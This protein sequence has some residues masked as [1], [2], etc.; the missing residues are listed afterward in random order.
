[1]V[2]AAA[3]LRGLRPALLAA[4][5]SASAYNF[6]FTA[7]YHTLLIDSPADVVTVVVL[8]LV[9]LVTSHLAASMRQQERLAKTHAARNATIAGFAR[10]L[11]SCGSEKDIAEVSTEELSRLF[12]CNAVLVVGRDD[13][14]LV[15]SVP[16]DMRLN[17]G[18]RAAMLLTFG[19]GAAAGRGIG[20]ANLADWQFHPVVSD[21]GVIA[22]LGL[23]RDDGVPPHLDLQ[24]P[25]LGSLLDQ[26]ALA[27]ERA[28]LERQAR[29]FATLRERDRIRLALLASIGQDVKPRLA[30]IMAAARALRRGGSSDKALVSSVAGEAAKL[31]LY[32][33]NLLTLS[34]AS[35]QKPVMAGAVTIDLFRRLVLKDGAE[36]HLTPKEYVV[37]A[38]LAKH[39]D[40]VLSHAYLLRTAWGPAHEA[41]ID[42]LRVA[43][44]ALRQKLERDPSRPEIIINEPA[45]GYR[46]KAQQLM[47]S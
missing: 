37:L 6:Y 22:A 32:I 27:L 45:V 38:E 30:A 25:L 31:N 21:E 42:Y 33:D 20:Q 18:D 2:L 14:E 44:R 23:A 28:G 29:E 3:V 7:P 36:I 47:A 35:E 11:L 16:T 8:F 39:P 46:L 9:A 13:P 17:P 10:R 5:A 34:P 19:T 24:L 40:R 15:A 41:Q 4:V 26:L 43:V 1:M 12:K